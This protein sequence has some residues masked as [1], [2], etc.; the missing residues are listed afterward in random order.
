MLPA[1]TS[2][3]C[4]EETG[5]H[6]YLL[7]SFEEG[8]GSIVPARVVNECKDLQLVRLVTRNLVDIRELTAPRLVEAVSN[9]QRECGTLPTAHG[10]DADKTDQ[11]AYS[12]SHNVT[13]LVGP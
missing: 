9:F 3:R 2:I 8:K 6:A 11:H 10:E 7:S 13:F 1:E 5:P 4:E 12:E